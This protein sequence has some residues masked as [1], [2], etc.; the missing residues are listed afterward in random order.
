[1]TQRQLAQRSGVDHS[2]ISRL[3]SEDRMPSLGTAL[4]LANALGGFPRDAAPIELD[5]PAKHP[6]AEVEYALRADDRLSDREVRQLMNH[7]LALRSD[8]AG[9]AARTSP[10]AARTS[11]AT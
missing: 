3:L 11:R 10:D 4:K 1:M 5:P 8:A 6:T 9:P 2:T 7:Y